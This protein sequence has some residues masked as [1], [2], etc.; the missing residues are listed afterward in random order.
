MIVCVNENWLKINQSFYYVLFNDCIRV[1]YDVHVHTVTTC[2]SI[3][4][5][6][7]FLIKIINH[8]FDNFLHEISVFMITED[9]WDIK[10]V[11]STEDYMR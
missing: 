4:L 5:Q 10:L 1:Y 2:T 11:T 6:Y 7:F 9:S 8:A 3:V